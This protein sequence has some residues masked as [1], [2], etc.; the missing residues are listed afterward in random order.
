M[1][2]KSISGWYNIFPGWEKTIIFIEGEEKIKLTYVCPF[3]FS[4]SQKRQLV[5]DVFIIFWE[6]QFYNT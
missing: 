6:V 1:V 5:E 4:Y 2:K 3:S